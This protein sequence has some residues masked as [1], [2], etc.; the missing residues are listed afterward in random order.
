[1]VR[2]LSASDPSDCA[3]MRRVARNIKIVYSENAIIVSLATD[4]EALVAEIERLRRLQDERN[5]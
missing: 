3:A 4:V 5:A 2:Q 1:M